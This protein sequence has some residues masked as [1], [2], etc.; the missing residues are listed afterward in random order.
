M[1]DDRGDD[2]IGYKTVVVRNIKLQLSALILFFW[3]GGPKC[4]R[5]RVS[6]YPG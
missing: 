3:G 2:S 1:L 5:D 4:G 6:Q